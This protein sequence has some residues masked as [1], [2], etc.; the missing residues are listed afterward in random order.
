MIFQS[1]AVLLLAEAA[2][3]PKCDFTVHC[4]HN[5]PVKIASLW[6]FI[7]TFCE[8][9]FSFL[10]SRCRNED[11]WH[12]QKN[13]NHILVLCLIILSDCIYAAY[14]EKQ[15]IKIQVFLILVLLAT[16][17]WHNAGCRF[18]FFKTSNSKDCWPNSIIAKVMFWQNYEIC[19]CLVICLQRNV[20]FLVFRTYSNVI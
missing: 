2:G 18:S 10:V 6:G 14:L 20:L 19:W 3:K 15:Q 1:L 12:L 11:I 13:S 4:E 8:L 17:R 16:Q 9:I 7:R 5:D